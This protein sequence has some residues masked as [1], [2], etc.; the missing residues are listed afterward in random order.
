MHTALIALLLTDCQLYCK[1][2]DAEMPTGYDQNVWD[3]Q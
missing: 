3:M 1:V 2:H